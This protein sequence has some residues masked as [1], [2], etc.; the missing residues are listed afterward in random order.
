MK[1]PAFCPLDAL[2]AYLGAIA[3]GL[4]GDGAIEQIARVTQCSRAGVYRLLDDLRGVGLVNGDRLV[5]FA[6]GL[7]VHS[8]APGEECAGEIVLTLAESADM[9]AC[10]AAGPLPCANLPLALLPEER[11][12]LAAELR[13]GAAEICVVRERRREKITPDDEYLFRLYS[14]RRVR[15]DVAWSGGRCPK[16]IADARRLLVRH[17]VEKPQ[18]AAYLDWLF[19]NFPKWSK[20]KLHSP[21]I[22]IVASQSVIDSFVA[23]LGERPLNW[24]RAVEILA[25]GG[26]ADVNVFVALDVA[27]IARAKNRDPRTLRGLDGRYPDAVAYLLERYAEIGILPTE[28]A[29][30]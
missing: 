9:L 11:A 26:F 14:A 15:I 28:E 2:R 6:K 25:E 8:H 12:K 13:Q 4:G 24:R 22:G 10:A 19:E 23:T 20:E 3:S 16:K 29:A 21:P 5:L 18:F 7:T 17:H 30:L 1:R 27:K